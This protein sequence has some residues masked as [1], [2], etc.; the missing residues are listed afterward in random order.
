LNE[1]DE[2]I[3]AVRMCK[4]PGDKGGISRAG[5]LREKNPEKGGAE[6]CSDKVTTGNE[7]RSSGPNERLGPPAI[8]EKQGSLKITRSGWV[9]SE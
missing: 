4:V 8:D 5:D 7:I 2:G 6:Q 3:F 1:G 9:S